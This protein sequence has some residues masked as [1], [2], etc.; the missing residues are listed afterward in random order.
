MLRRSFLAAIALSALALALPPARGQDVWQ[1]QAGRLAE[2]LHWHPGAVVAEIGAGEGE[3]TLLAAQRVGP[4]G[5]VYSTELEPR[6]AHLKEVTAKERNITAVKAAQS[7]TN[8]PPACC[9]SIYMRT[10]YHHF[11]KPAE[12]D[13]SIFRSLKPGGRL[14][15]IDRE[16]PPGST[17]PEGVPKNRGGHGMPQK[18]L[19]TEL[20]AAGFSVEEIINDWPGLSEAFKTYCVVFRKPGSS[21]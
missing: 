14:A 1:Q 6:L 11:T 18:L 13:A 2:L 15:V 10:V 21:R 16:P 19:I 12:I 5:R 20:T 8:L 17:I 7:A 9:D 4:S 3:L